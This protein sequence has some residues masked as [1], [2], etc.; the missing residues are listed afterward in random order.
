[1]ELH[2][3]MGFEFFVVGFEIEV[4]F[5]GGTHGETPIAI[6]SLFFRFSSSGAKS[7]IVHPCAIDSILL[8]VEVVARAGY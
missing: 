1:M 2:S 4:Q 6:V 7:P 5:E 3:A 8:F